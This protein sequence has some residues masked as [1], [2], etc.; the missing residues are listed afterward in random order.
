LSVQILLLLALLSFLAGLWL[1]SIRRADFTQLGRI[2]LFSAIL[3][4]FAV[5]A[6]A[7]VNHHVY[8]AFLEDRHNQ[9]VKVLGQTISELESQRL[10]GF[11]ESA[12]EERWWKSMSD[13]PG[14]SDVKAKIE[15]IKKTALEMIDKIIDLIVV[16]VLS[17]IALALLFLWGLIKLGRLIFVQGFSVVAGER[18]AEK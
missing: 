11:P 15:A 13:L 1:P 6:M 12:E 10:S 9:S 5:P 4:R 14:M 7:Y 17:T 3:L 2:L 18:P 8:V 16:F